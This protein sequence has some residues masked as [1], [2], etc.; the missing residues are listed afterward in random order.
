MDDQA[1][2]SLEQHKVEMVKWDV[3]HLE[4]VNTEKVNRATEALPEKR[5][6]FQ[7]ESHSDSGEHKIGG[8]VRYGSKHIK[9]TVQYGSRLDQR[10]IDG[11]WGASNSQVM[12]PRCVTPVDSEQAMRKSHV[13]VLVTADRFKVEMYI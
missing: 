10:I 8:S 9:V 1:A 7:E 12:G 2:S 6:I 5:V 4:K 11:R 13:K 3:E